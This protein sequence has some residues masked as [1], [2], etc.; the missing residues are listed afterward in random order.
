MVDGRVAAHTCTIF[1]FFQARC[2][3]TLPCMFKAG[4]VT[5]VYSPIPRFDGNGRAASCSPFSTAALQL[6]LLII[7]KLTTAEHTPS[8]FT[9]Q[10]CRRLY[11]SCHLCRANLHKHSGTLEYS[12]VCFSRV[13]AL[14]GAVAV[15]KIQFRWLPHPHGCRLALALQD[16]SMEATALCESIFQFVGH[17]GPE[18]GST[19]DLP[20]PSTK[21]VRA[22]EVGEGATASAAA[23][24]TRNGQP[25]AQPLPMEAE[26]YYNTSTSPKH[27]MENEE[28]MRAFVG[29]KA[30][31]WRF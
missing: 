15:Y 31:R 22:G 11:P 30:S 5:I 12:S 9:S 13:A 27:Q 26:R 8:S 21:T 23:S 20:I 17:G 3:N 1:F 25:T 18:H 6:L 2:S 10:L 28:I 4:L 29:N 24:K 14:V 7:I 19:S 16:R